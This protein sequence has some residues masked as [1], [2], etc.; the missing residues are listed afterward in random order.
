MFTTKLTINNILPLL[1]IVASIGLYGCTEPS[2]TAATAA[3]EVESEYTD[4]IDQEDQ[5]SLTPQDALNMLKEGNQRFLQD[6]MI[7]RDLI[8]QVEKTASG[9][10]PHAV[11]LGCIDSRVP[12]ELVFD[13]GIGDI[14]TPRIAGNFVNTDIIGSMEFATAVAGS[15][16]IVVLGHSECGAVKGACD[17]V[18]LGN[19]TSTLANLMPAVNGVQDVEGERNSQNKAFVDEVIH[20]NVELTID[21]IMN[22]SPI[23]ADLV[24]EGSLMIVGA[25][26][27]VSTGQVTFLN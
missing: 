19:L 22:E 23:M 7:N 4:V 3:T 9:Q 18:E 8:T 27:N 21:Q 12:P 25:I 15:K 6:E 2:Q 14:F 5:A 13:Q 17:G 24:E 1:F 20:L 26:H 16:L 10:Y 11:V